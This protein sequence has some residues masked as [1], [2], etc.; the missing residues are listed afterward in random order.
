MTQLMVSVRNASE[1]RIA[2]SAGVRV[3]DIKEPRLG[4]LGRAD[5]RVIREI[6]S[7]VPSDVALSVALGEL[8]VDTGFDLPRSLARC[9]FAKIGLAGCRG[10]E[11]WLHLW[12][13]ALAKIPLGTTPVAVIYAD[14]VADV[15]EYEEIL[16]Y[17]H[18]FGCQAALL[19][20]YDKDSGGLLQSARFPQIERFVSVAR[21]LNMTVAWRVV[22]IK[23]M[24]L[25]SLA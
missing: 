15:P 10:R 5:D 19:D 23:R 21:S 20:T 8:L 25:G 22:L 3:L 7:A 6:C 14:V 1:A 24:S 17:G 9:S 12:K 16:E 4:A 18:E 13:N 11:D 2:L